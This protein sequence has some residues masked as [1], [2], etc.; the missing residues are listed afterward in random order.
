M[1]F[2]IC[3][4]PWYLPY[5][6]I[7]LLFASCRWDSIC[8]SSITTSGA[9]GLWNDHMWPKFPGSKLW[10]KRRWRVADNISEQITPHVPE[11]HYKTCAVEKAQ[12]MGL[13]QLRCE[14]FI[15]LNNAVFVLVFVSFFFFFLILRWWIEL[16]A[17]YLN[18][19]ELNDLNLNSCRNLHSGTV[20]YAYFKLIIYLSAV[21]LFPLLL[22]KWLC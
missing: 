20:P 5:G 9:Y 22:A 10:W 16:Q 3:Y 21:W 8:Y 11:A 6:L 7:I 12:L 18:C 14:P 17:L 1:W 4:I 2:Y 13:L 19:P 15:I